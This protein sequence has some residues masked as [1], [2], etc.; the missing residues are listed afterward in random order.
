ME[1]VIYDGMIYLNFVVQGNYDTPPHKGL[2]DL[3]DKP[4]EKLLKME[5]N[6]LDDDLFNLKYS[7]LAKYWK[8]HT[9]LE[10][11]ANSVFNTIN[12]GLTKFEKTNIHMEDLDFF[13]TETMRK[14]M[15]RIFVENPSKLS[16]QLYPEYEK[17]KIPPD[18]EEKYYLNNL[19]TS[20][21]KINDFSYVSKCSKEEEVCPHESDYL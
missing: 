16:L 18:T 4:I 5:Q 20:T 12:L 7:L 17:E 21:I 11:T 13:T 9:S 8:N 19:I 15:K 6:I 10:K 1:K 14:E 2:N 3:A